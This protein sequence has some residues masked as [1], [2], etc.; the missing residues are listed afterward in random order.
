MHTIAPR[1]NLLEAIR[2]AVQNGGTFSGYE[3]ETS[4]KLFAEEQ[5]NHTS[6]SP[7][8]LRVPL[9]ILARDLNFVTKESNLVTPDV[10]ESRSVRS[11]VQSFE[12]G[13]YWTRDM[14]AGVSASGGATVQTDVD[15]AVIEFLRP[16]SV[17]LSMGAQFISGLKGNVV[18]PRFT[19]TA[20]P[21]FLSERDPAPESSQTMGYMLMKPHRVVGWVTVSKTLLTQTSGNA[22]KMIIDDIRS[23]I[24]SAIDLGSIAGTSADGQPMGVLNTTGCASVTFGGS[25]TW[26]KVLDF[27]DGVGS[28]DADKGALGWVMSSATRKAWKATQRGAGISR[29]LWDSDGIAGYSAMA[30]N[31]LNTDRANDRVIFGNW[32]DL[33]IGSWGLNTFDL[34]VDGYTLAYKGQVRL[35]VSSYIDCGVRHGSSFAISTD[36]GIQ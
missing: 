4:D 29:Y 20:T 11:V 6:H 8:G 23:A 27:E 1:Y 22:G 7:A 34:I 10:S 17:A 31:Q 9:G 30:S 3:K 2:N 24:G 15:R 19:G 13:N 36:S 32:N 21:Q 12:R 16:K 25:A 26:Q 33:I 28:R 35:I 18:F 5:W 14:S